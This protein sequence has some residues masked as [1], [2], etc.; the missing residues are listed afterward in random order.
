MEELISCTIWHFRHEERLMIRYKYEDFENHKAEH[1]ELI[2]SAKELQK[3]FHQENKL[4]TG[5]DIEYLA[6]WLT[7]HILSRDMRL[8]FYLGKVME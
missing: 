4:L 2:D 6:D 1:N 8:G 5:E 7:G 3:K